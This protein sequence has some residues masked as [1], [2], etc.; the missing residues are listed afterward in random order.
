MESG[1]TSAD[2]DNALLKEYSDDGTDIDAR[3]SLMK[4][5]H[6][7]YVTTREL[8]ARVTEFS[9]MAFPEEVRDNAAIQV[10]LEDLF[11]GKLMHQTRRE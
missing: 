7:S 10:Q 1:L 5:T 8:E 11:L 3:R 6:A 4:L 9:T 2:L